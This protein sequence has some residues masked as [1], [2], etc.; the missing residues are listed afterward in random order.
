MVTVPALIP[1]RFPEDEIVATKGF[2]LDQVP[3]DVAFVN[4]VELF[5]HTAFAPLIALTGL[6]VNTFTAVDSEFAEQPFA[7]VTVT[8]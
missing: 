3:P 6:G 1:V 8:V 7:P 2:E 5:T 4:V